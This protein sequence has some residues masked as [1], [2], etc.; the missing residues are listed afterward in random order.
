L[1]SLALQPKRL[2]VEKFV[3][4]SALPKFLGPNA[5][6]F[7]MNAVVDAVEVVRSS[8]RSQS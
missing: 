8:S 3:T 2:T 1:V 7:A 5:R 6:S 4:K